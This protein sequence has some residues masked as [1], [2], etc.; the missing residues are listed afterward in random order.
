[1]MIF[2]KEYVG[3]IKESLNKIVDQVSRARFYIYEMYYYINEE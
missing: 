3:F 1:M 2:L